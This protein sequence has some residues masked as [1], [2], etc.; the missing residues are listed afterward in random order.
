MVRRVLF[1]SERGEIHDIV[2][3]DESSLKRSIDV[4]GTYYQPYGGAD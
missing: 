1:V 4:D 2:G 3:Y